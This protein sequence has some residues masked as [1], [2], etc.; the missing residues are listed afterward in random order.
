[1]TVI[2]GLP[3]HVLFVHAVVVL[4]P[5]AALLTVLT[6]VWPAARRRLG[7][8]TPVLALVAA[9]F[10]PLTTHAGEALLG[11]VPNTALVRRHAGLG[12]LLVP[13]AVLL[14][15]AAAAVWWV[16]RLVEGAAAAGA[17]RGGVTGVLARPWLRTAV[18]V[19]AVLIGVGTVVATVLIGD[20][21][22]QAAWGD[23]RAQ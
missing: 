10:V 1:M 14:V 11:Q 13:W 8:V 6:A 19:L 21:G 5:L 15:L 3:A 22:A 16:P 4:V 2:N 7:L 17:P 18:S 9:A 23:V 12:D 20:S